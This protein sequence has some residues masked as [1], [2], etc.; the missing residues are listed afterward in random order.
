MPE[1]HSSLTAWINENNFLSFHVPPE[2]SAEQQVL[3][4][5]I[6]NLDHLAHDRLKPET[7]QWNEVLGILLNA[8]ITG[9]TANDPAQ[10]RLIYERAEEAFYHHIQTR[11]RVKYL[12]GMMIGVVV[13]GALGGTLSLLSRFLEESFITPEL[14]VLLFVF[15]GMGSI[16]SVLTRLSSIDLRKETSDRMVMVSG[17]ARLVVAIFFAMVVYLILD[18]RIVEF[19]FGDPSGARRDELYLVASFLCGFSERFA[20][21]IISRVS[22]NK[23]D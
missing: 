9:V 14:L 16:A 4:A 22:L 6:V 7:P 8:A 21:D 13:A 19:Q 5:D 20:Q 1:D 17:A 23:T 11:N 10:G 3:I 18:L 2:P 12:L 15:A